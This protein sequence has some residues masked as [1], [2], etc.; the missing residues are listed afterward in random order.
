[1]EFVTDIIKISTIMIIIIVILTT[2]GILFI[3]STSKAT[4]ETQRFE[5]IEE[6]IINNYN[7]GC[8]VY[9]TETK[10]MYLYQYKGGYTV[11][12]DNEGQPLLY[13]E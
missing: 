5:Y 3:G 1:M 8:I 2:L 4:N 13:Q 9:D 7:N 11:M 10:V 6:V 12:V